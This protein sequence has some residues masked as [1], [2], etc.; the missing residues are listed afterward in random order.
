MA[1]LFGLGWLF[2]FF[3]FGLAF[4]WG[5]TVPGELGGAISGSAGACALLSLVDWRLPDFKGALL[6]VWR[7]F[8]L[9][10]RLKSFRKTGPPK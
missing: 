9:D 4:I 2:S 6:A 5:T 3:S 8:F 10:E 7:A 1:R